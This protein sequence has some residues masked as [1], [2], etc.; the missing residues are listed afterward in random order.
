[1][2]RLLLVRHGI[3]AYNSS[4]RFAGYSD[5]EL[6]EE[7][8]QQVESL[9]DYLASERIDAAYSSDLKRA[10]VT[11]EVICAGRDLDIITCPE[12]REANYG[13]IEGLTFEEISQHHPE[14]AELVANFDLSLKFPGGESF[15]GFIERTVRFLDRLDQHGPSE[16]ILIVSH[17]GPLRTLACQLLGIGQGCWWQLRFDNAS[18]S[19]LDTYP[20]G[21]ILTRLNDVSHL[22]ETD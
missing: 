9:R 21:V 12:L 13:E 10:L 6:S 20:R 19:I 11:A 5:V 22:R 4:R 18:L 1:M 8:H 3:T 15:E 14:V 17:S 16:T 7:G 2:S